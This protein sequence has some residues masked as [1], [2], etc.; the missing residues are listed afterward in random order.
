M[1][2]SPPKKSFTIL[3][4]FDTICWPRKLIRL[5]VILFKPRSVKIA[6][7]DRILH[8]MSNVSVPSEKKK[9]K[10]QVTQLGRL[11]TVIDS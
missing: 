3:A 9:R 2:D 4:D 5:V 8:L 1:I 11:L 7:A 10:R 6:D